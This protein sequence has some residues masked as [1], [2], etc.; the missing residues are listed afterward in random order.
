M[1]IAKL[2][3]P[4]PLYYILCVQMNQV[5]TVA[6]FEEAKNTFIRTSEAI[7]SC[8]HEV[9]CL[10]TSQSAHIDHSEAALL[11]IIGDL[12]STCQLIHNNNADLYTVWKRLNMEDR[13]SKK[14]YINYT[15]DHVSNIVSIL[16]G[17]GASVRPIMD[18]IRQQLVNT[19]SIKDTQMLSHLACAASTRLMGSINQPVLHETPH[20]AVATRRELIRRHINFT[21]MSDHETRDDNK[22]ANLQGQWLAHQVKL[23]SGQTTPFP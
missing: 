12:F 9:D 5:Q 6:G 15:I 8:I 21:D 4:L 16:S 18:K 11:H 10:T 17:E 7:R 20:P 2:F 13:E 3:S 19:T 23:R 1:H 22:A 14:K